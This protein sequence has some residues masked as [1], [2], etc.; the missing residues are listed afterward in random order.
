MLSIEEPSAGASVAAPAAGTHS[1]PS[2]QRLT[3]PDGAELAYRSLAHVP[4]SEAPL[5]QALLVLHSTLSS[6]WQLKGLARLASQWATVV[7]PDR[8]GSGA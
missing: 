7:L 2:L 3:R 4:T 1:M 6:G 5:A 8:R